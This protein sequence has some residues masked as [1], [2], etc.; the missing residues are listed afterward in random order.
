[1]VARLQ[2]FTATF[3]VLALFA[4]YTAGACPTIYVGDS[5]ELAAAVHVLGIPH[6][7]SYPLYVL[8]GKLWT[9]LVP[10]GSVAY[11]LSLFSA[12]C[13]AL[14]CAALYRAGREL[15]LPL[16]AALLSALVFAFGS[17]FW[18]EANVQ[19]VYALNALLVALATLAA[20][21]WNARRD[22]RW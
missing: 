21:R 16:P 4:V 19:R 1:M 5:G 13:A 22:P 17:S 11:R 20:L 6:P 12:L 3:V 18:G 15:Q 10:I 14:A 7:T 8:L 2:P 9:V